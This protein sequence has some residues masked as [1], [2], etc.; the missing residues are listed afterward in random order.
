MLS[1]LLLA[2]AHAD[3]LGIYVGAQAWQN[4]GTGGFAEEATLQR[5]SFD[6]DTNA[7]FHLNFEH[8]LPLIPNVRVRTGKLTATGNTDLT[9]EFTFNGQ[10]YTT[11]QT[12]DTDLDFTNTDITAYY[13]LLDNDLVG[14]DVGLTAKYLSGDFDVKNSSGVRA[15]EDASLW[16]PMGYV[17]G[18]VALPGTGLYVYG[19]INMVSYDDNSVHDYQVGLGYSFVDNFAIDASLQLG[20]REVAIDIEDV[21]DIYADL[22]F[23]GLFAGV[24]LHF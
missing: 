3:T 2:P 18:K 4:E 7:S 10:T 9:R 6:E 19:D 11:G 23:S 17:A 24:E 12:L 16:L 14:L 21:D 20:Y 15:A 22:E 1:A 13:E 5:F 8:P